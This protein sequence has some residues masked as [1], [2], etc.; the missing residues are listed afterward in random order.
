MTWSDLVAVNTQEVG[1]LVNGEGRQEPLGRPSLLQRGFPSIFSICTLQPIA[2][3]LS[4]RPW[5]RAR[6]LVGSTR[7]CLIPHGEVETPQAS[8]SGQLDS[9]PCSTPYKWCD[10]EEVS[11][12]LWAWF[13]PLEH[14]ENAKLIGLFGGLEQ[15]KCISVVFIVWAPPEQQLQRHRG[16]C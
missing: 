7:S 5:P 9:R 11:H 13:S 3:T 15:K 6:C 14:G 4:S 10:A 8:E 16:I 12:I 2:D 1:H